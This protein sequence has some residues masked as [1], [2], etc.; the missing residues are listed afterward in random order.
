MSHPDDC[1]SQLLVA[2]QFV[3]PRVQ[4]FC[5]L[6][7]QMSFMPSCQGL[8]TC[9]FT[10]EQ[11]AHTRDSLHPHTPSYGASYLQQASIQWPAGL[12]PSP[13]Q[14]LCR[15]IAPGHLLLDEW[16]TFNSH[17]SWPL[18]EDNSLIIHFETILQLPSASRTM[19]QHLIICCQMGLSRGFTAPS[20]PHS[21][22]VYEAPTGWMTSSGCC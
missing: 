20:K 18:F 21:K 10:S 3:W 2:K 1:G 17:S 6:E 12:K 15:R 7:L 11:D 5:M 4:R 22:P 14:T 16:S 19:E 8:S 9:P 13:C